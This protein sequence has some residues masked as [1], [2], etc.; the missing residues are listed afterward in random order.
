MPRKKLPEEV[1]EFFRQQG[2]KGGKLSGPARMRKL[3]PE[4]R[5]EIARKAV[6]AREANR[7]KRKDQT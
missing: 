6:A 7:R 2:A 1:L 5:S 3:T 4:H